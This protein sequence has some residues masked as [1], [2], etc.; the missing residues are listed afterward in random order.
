[1]TKKQLNNRRWFYIFIG[2][3]VG[4]IYINL[5][6]ND[7]LLP[8]LHKAMDNEVW[9]LLLYPIPAFPIFFGIGG[10]LY[11]ESIKED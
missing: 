1:M 9:G 10:S 5:F 8:E 11:L 6:G 7:P 4:V 2:L 3:V